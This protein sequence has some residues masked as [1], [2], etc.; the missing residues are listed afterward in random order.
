[1]QVAEQAL[2][3]SF[4]AGGTPLAASSAASS[5]A[6][7]PLESR[8]TSSCR[9]LSTIAAGGV[10]NGPP[11]LRLNYG[12]HYYAAFVIDPDGHHIEAVFKGPA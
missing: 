3:H 2:H 7:C 6:V 11:G 10:D 8:I 4:R 1:M 9:A 5:N 12:Q